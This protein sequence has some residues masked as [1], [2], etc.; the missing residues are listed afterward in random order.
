MR[1]G[2]LQ[3]SAPI[4]GSSTGAVAAEHQ[5]GAAIGLARRIAKRDML[6]R[7]SMQTSGRPAA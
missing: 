5:H 1:P 7:A 4:N 3:Q 2:D 6:A